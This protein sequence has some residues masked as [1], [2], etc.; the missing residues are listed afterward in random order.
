[1]VEQN[2]YIFLFL[3]FR[4]MFVAINAKA[5]ASKPGHDAAQ[6][7]LSD[8]CLPAGLR[9]LVL[10]QWG[11]MFYCQNCRLYPIQLRVSIFYIDGA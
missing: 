11:H 1:M 2:F 9:G 4:S 7:H 10:P 5:E 8:V 6:H 3:F